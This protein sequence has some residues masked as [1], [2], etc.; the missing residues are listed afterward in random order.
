MPQ[1][2]RKAASKTPEARVVEGPLGHT[3]SYD[4]KTKTLSL[5]PDAD[6][7]EILHEYF[8]HIDYSLATH[9][10]PTVSIDEHSLIGKQIRREIARFGNMG[11]ALQEIER[12]TAGDLNLEDLFGALT[13]N[14]IGGGHPTEYFIENWGSQ[15]REIFANLGSLF[16]SGNRWS[17]VKAVAPELAAAFET[18]ISA[19]S[20]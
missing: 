13:F 9:G 6:A 19:E 1:S 11:E 7:A 14:K 10:A 15:Y 8:H 3:S 12:R 16:S 5:A 18:W 4:S 17:R 20:K 2:A